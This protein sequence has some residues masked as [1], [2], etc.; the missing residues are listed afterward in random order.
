MTLAL[1]I[2]RIARRGLDLALVALVVVVVTGLLIAR[3]VPI[4]TGAPVLVVG[5]GSMEPAIHLGSLAVDQ[6][7]GADSLAVGDVVS[8][9]VGPQQS[10]FTHRI[11]RV[12]PREDGLWIETKGDANA[13]IDPSIVPASAVI[14][15]VALVIPL[16]G[17][18][19]Q[20]LGTL[21]GLALLFMLG[22]IALAGTFALELVE[23]ELV[24]ARHRLRPFR[25]HALL[26]TGRIGQEIDPEMPR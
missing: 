10:V 13:T 17:Y 19:V 24:D 22:V 1:T 25:V 3:L 21:S 15:R 6:P 2:V 5:G 11:T 20:L 16:L 8:M 26:R 4:A 14:G 7:V 9:K 12:V 18:V 23:E